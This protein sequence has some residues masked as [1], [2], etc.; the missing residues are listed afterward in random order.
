MWSCDDHL[1]LLLLL[2]PAV[3]SLLLAGMPLLQQQD[4][5]VHLIQPIDPLEQHKQHKLHPHQRAS[6][7]ASY[8]L[9]AADVAAAAGA[10]WCF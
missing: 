7:S 1:L 6:G 2:P 3:K 10:V 5:W 9:A 4:L 8:R